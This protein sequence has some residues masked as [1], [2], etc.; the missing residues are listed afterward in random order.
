M[1]SLLI[2]KKIISTSI[3]EKI[4]QSENYILLLNLLHIIESNTT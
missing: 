3:S 4:I 2:D 1:N